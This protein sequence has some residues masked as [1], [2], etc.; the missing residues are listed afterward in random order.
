MA[1]ILCRMCP[2][3]FFFADFVP[4]GEHVVPSLTAFNILVTSRVTEKTNIGYCAMIPHPASNMSTIYT[5]METFQDMMRILGQLKS[6]L[7]LD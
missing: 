4:I 1:W 7:T 6:V 2:T 3:K 5:L